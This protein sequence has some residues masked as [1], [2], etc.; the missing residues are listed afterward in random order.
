[1]KNGKKLQTQNIFKKVGNMK[2]DYFFCEQFYIGAIYSF[3]CMYSY[4]LISS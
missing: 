1:M 4:I 3:L 2:T